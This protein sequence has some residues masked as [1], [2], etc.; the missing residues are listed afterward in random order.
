GRD[1]VYVFYTLPGGR[2]DRVERINSAGT[3]EVL[4]RALPSGSP[5]HHG[6]ILAFGP[7]G[8]LYVSHGEAHD[9]DRAQ[10]PRELGGKIYRINPDGS[11]PD[12]NPFEGEPTWSYGHRNPFG[13]TF[14]P[15]NGSLWETENGPEA[16]DE[17]N[18]IER[19]KNYGWPIA[20]GNSG[21]DRFVDPVVDYENIVVPT[22]IAFAPKAFG[23]EHVHDVF[24]GTYQQGSIRRLFLDADRTRVTSDTLFARIP[25][26]VTALARG[27]D[28]LYA[29]T[30][31]AVI[32]LSVA[33]GASPSPSDTP[34]AHPPREDDDESPLGGSTQGRIQGF[35]VITTAALGG[36]VLSRWLRD[37][38]NRDRREPR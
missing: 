21:D 17:V 13:L 28:G 9:Q 5:Y 31:D 6:G 27:P 1:W 29:A 10:Q 32:R 2:N 23:E 24:V 18:I 25:G 16:H 12:D 19:G 8:K 7:D 36:F 15:K 30:P 3:R 14:D 4:M 22:G 20:R 37:R 35:L 26:G 34:P 38:L 33:G 11:I